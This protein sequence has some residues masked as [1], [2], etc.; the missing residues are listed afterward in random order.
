MA[1]E[2]YDEECE[3]EYEEEDY[4]WDPWYEQEA[5]EEIFGDEVEEELL[6]EEEGW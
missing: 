3:E 5:F 2:E 6:A 4:S 1:E